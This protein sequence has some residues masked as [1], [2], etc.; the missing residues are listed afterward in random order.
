MSTF[1]A[2]AYQ[3]RY[4]RDYPKSPKGY[5]VMKFARYKL[6]AKRRGFKF[7]LTKE[8]FISLCQEECFY[9]GSP[10]PNGLDRLD[11][12]KGYDLA[13]AVACCTKHNSMK[14]KMSV[15]EFAGECNKVDTYFKE[16]R[17]KMARIVVHI[18]DKE[19]GNVKITATPT[20]EEMAMKV[21]SGETITAA[22]TYALFAL[23]KIREASKSLDMKHGRQVPDIN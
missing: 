10:G 5:W 15:E 20:F 16:R 9:C 13:N 21:D 18:E 2:K 7:N 22:E 23:R 4:Q 12:S 11:N 19:D 8:L 1:D 17:S 3:K 14:S 6:Q